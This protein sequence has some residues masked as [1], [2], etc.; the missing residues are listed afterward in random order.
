MTIGD[1]VVRVCGIGL[2]IELCNILNCKLVV[3]AVDPSTDV[4]CV[5]VVETDTLT[6]KDGCENLQPKCGWQLPCI[7]CL[8]FV[9]EHI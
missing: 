5:C 8:E 4:G 2:Q 1:D 7:E 6:L 3:L 9:A